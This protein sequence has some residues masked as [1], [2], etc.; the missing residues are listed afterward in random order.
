MKKV[1]V[2]SA[3]PPSPYSAGQ[4]FT[5]T[6]LSDLAKD[7]QIDFV[8]FAFRHQTY[9]SPSPLI[10]VV[11]KIPLST[12]HRILNVF[13]CPVF[14]PLFSV[15]FSISTLWFLRKLVRTNSYDVLCFDFS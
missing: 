4:N 13:L 3:F 11:K 14:H 2:I 7:H 12:V 1:L 9:T 6:L 10:R 8:Y 15:R 5:N